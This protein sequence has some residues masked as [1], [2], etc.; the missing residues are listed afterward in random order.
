MEALGGALRFT[1]NGLYLFGIREAH[2][3]HGCDHNHDPERNALRVRSATTSHSTCNLPGLREVVFAQ[4]GVSI[5][6][7]VP[8]MVDIGEDMMIWDQ[9]IRTIGFSY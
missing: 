2:C 3:R 4:H 5:A 9:V 7:D 8:I 1:V 6:E